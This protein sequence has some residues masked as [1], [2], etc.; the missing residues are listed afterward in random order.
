MTVSQHGAFLDWGR[1]PFLLGTFRAASLPSIRAAPVHK[2][3][4]LLHACQEGRKDPPFMHTDAC[5]PCSVLRG[6]KAMLSALI[7]C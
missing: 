3:A 5:C 7:D 2:H 4:P 1:C 6:E